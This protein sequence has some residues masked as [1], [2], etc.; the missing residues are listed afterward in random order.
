MCDNTMRM[1]SL[2]E[3]LCR[4]RYLETHDGQHGLDG[5][6]SL[7]NSLYHKMFRPALFTV[8][9]Q[10]IAIEDVCFQHPKNILQLYGAGH[11]G[12]IL[13]AASVIYSDKVT[14][15]MTQHRVTN[16][17]QI[18]NTDHDITHT[19]IKKLIGHKSLKDDTVEV[20]TRH[21][22]YYKFS[23]P[24]QISFVYNVVLNCGVIFNRN[25]STRYISLDNMRGAR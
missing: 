10:Q 15:T 9:I 5:G 7:S 22:L 21:I 19:M 12:Q 17:W 23:A 18:C 1:I 14:V 20:A 24:S 16:S 11:A 2:F 3:E 8:I 6:S 13:G 4:C 25:I